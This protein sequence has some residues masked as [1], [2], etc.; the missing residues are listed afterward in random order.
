QAFAQ[1]IFTLFEKAIETTDAT[2]FYENYFSVPD[3][4]NFFDFKTRLNWLAFGSYLPGPDTK[5]EF[6]DEMAD[7]VNTTPAGLQLPMLDK[8]MYM[9]REKFL[10]SY[11]YSFGA[12]NAPELFAN[13]AICPAPKKEEIKNLAL[14]HSGKFTY[15]GSENNHFLFRH[16]FTKTLYK[17]RQDSVQAPPTDDK[18]KKTYDFSVIKWNNDWWITGMMV[19]N[20]LKPAEIANYQKQP[21]TKFWMYGPE[22]AEKLQKSV[23]LMHASFVEY[24]GSPLATFNSP[25]ELESSLQDY[26]DFHAEKQGAADENYRKKRLSS[27]KEQEKLTASAI[28][29]LPDEEKPTGI[30]FVKGVGTV[31]ISNIAEIIRRMEAESLSSDEQLKLFLDLSINL[32]PAVAEYLLQHYPT[33]NVKFPIPGSQ[34]DALE[35]MAYFWR[36]YNP[37]EFGPIYPLVTTVEF[38]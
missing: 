28:Q 12:L 6:N 1:D 4:L 24:Y 3:T 17:V 22:E 36:Y 32:L 26:F 8:I 13:L 15:E 16:L 10:Y 21:F 7:L 30:F 18:A 25:E 31:T 38:E 19:V 9:Y 33:K 14:V 37:E 11:R 27:R 29:N 34:V 23:D 2:D 35:N 20:E 5:R